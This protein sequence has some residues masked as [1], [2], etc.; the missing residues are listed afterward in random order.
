MSSLKALQKTL[1]RTGQRS[2]LASSAEP[3]S[4]AGRGAWNS[5][6]H[7]SLSTQLQ[8]FNRMPF[9][10][11]ADSRGKPAMAAPD[12]RPPLAPHWNANA[13]RLSSTAAKTSMEDFDALY[14]YEYETGPSGNLFE[15]RDPQ[16]AYPQW[17]TGRSASIQRTYSAGDNAQGLLVCGGS[18]LAKHASFDP[19]YSRAQGWIRQHAVGPAVVSPVL[20][21]GL[22]GALVEAAL[23]NSV[24]IESSMQQIRPLIVGVKV[25]AEVEVDLAEAKVNVNTAS[26]P[27]MPAD[28]SLDYQNG[29]LSSMKNSGK[30]D[31]YHIQMTT[32][33]ERLQDGA[34]IAT[35]TQSV[36]IPYTTT[37]TMM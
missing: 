21:S 12:A 28:T 14:E 2:V 22:I 11:A 3:A 23:P 25:R 6:F 17:I 13:S 24:P 31:G 16:T 8:S 30:C 32:R 9:A 29:D 18:N 10:G 5:G 15:Q 35:G 7:R 27:A 37:M 4:A 19:N 36:W 20:I 26:A 34:M 1:Y 33:V